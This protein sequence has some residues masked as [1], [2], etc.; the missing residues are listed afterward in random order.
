MSEETINT[1]ERRREDA[2]DEGLDVTLSLPKGVYKEANWHDDVP[3]EAADEEKK[4]ETSYEFFKKE[5]NYESPQGD[6][7]DDLER[8]LVLF[9]RARLRRTG[10]KALRFVGKVA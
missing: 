2:S 6:V 8:R 9:R 3:L 4:E 1:I 7:E 10:N 5:W